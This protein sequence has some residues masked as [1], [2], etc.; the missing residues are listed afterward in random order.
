M[1]AMMVANAMGGNSPSLCPGRVH[2]G[3]PPNPVRDFMKLLSGLRN[4][5]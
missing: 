1:A 5:Q 4:V 2:T 3:T